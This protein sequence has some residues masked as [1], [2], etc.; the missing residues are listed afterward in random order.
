[1]SSPINYIINQY[2]AK[3]GWFLKAYEP[4]TTTEKLISFDPQDLITLDKVEVASDGF[5]KHPVTGKNTILYNS[6][7]F[8]LYLIPT[9]SE[10]DS[11]D[12]TNAIKLADNVTADKDIVS[13]N[14]PNA[15]EEVYGLVRFATEAESQ[16]TTP[17]DENLGM[18]PKNLDIIATDNLSNLKASPSEIT[19]QSDGKWITAEDYDTIKQQYIPATPVH[20][21]EI[22][23]TF[24]KHVSQVDNKW[25]LQDGSPFSQSSHPTL[26]SLPDYVNYATDLTSITQGTNN[27]KI[28]SADDVDGAINFIKI[29][30]TKYFGI[31]RFKNELYFAISENLLTWSTYM[32]PLSDSG[33]DEI[34]PFKYLLAYNP[35]SDSIGA[36]RVSIGN[37]PE[38]RYYEIY[39]N[40]NNNNI[41]YL[42]EKEIIKDYNNLSTIDEFHY[43]EQINKYVIFSQHFNDRFPVFLYDQLIDIQETIIISNGDITYN[44][45]T[46]SLFFSLGIKN[47][48]N[49]NFLGGLKYYNGFYYLAAKFYVNDIYY[50][51]LLLKI[52]ENDFSYSIIDEKFISLPID[53][54]RD[55]AIN[56]NG[57]LACVISYDQTDGRVE[58]LKS[59]D[60]TTFSTVIMDTAFT[61]LNA[62]CYITPIKNYWLI[63]SNNDINTA[64]TKDLS[65]IDLETT[66]S[67]TGS[68]DYSVA[69]YNPATNEIYEFVSGQEPA[70]IY[71]IKNQAVSEVTYKTIKMV[72]TAEGSSQIV[73]FSNPTK[74]NFINTGVSS[75]S[76]KYIK[77][78]DNLY[79]GYIYEDL[80]DTEQYN[81]I[82][83]TDGENWT[84]L[85]ISQTGRSFAPHL[86]V[87]LTWDGGDYILI[88]VDAQQNISLFQISTETFST[89]NYN[90]FNSGSPSISGGNCLSHYNQNLGKFI[91]FNNRDD[92]NTLYVT[93]FENTPATRTVTTI[94]ATGMN[95]DYRFGMVQ[96]NQNYMYYKNGKYYIYDITNFKLYSLEEGVWDLTLV[97][98]F[99]PTLTPISGVDISPVFF[100][101][102][103]IMTFPISY[104][105]TTKE[106]EVAYSED[107]I[108]FE[109]RVITLPVGS[110]SISKPIVFPFG[111]VWVV[112][113]IDG[114][115]INITKD[116]S[117][118]LY[119]KNDWSNEGSG[120][121]MFFHYDEINQKAIQY[122][123]GSATDSP[124]NPIYTQTLDV[125][126]EV[127][128]SDPTFKS[129][130]YGD[131]KPYV[132]AG[133]PQV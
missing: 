10:A 48:K 5:F 125:A 128:A 96:S 9:E 80:I 22:G 92:L 26:A 11:D 77:I 93:E 23:D 28:L 105:D 54:L 34:D 82:K 103:G 116:F 87:K 130:E 64:Y 83:S 75:G 74:E 100:N 126:V 30:D 131:V 56:E 132:F 37:N 90:M 133:T 115:D 36:I 16:A 53:S 104:N 55:L 67:V 98:T 95:F 97:N 41:T 35:N 86:N 19:A 21:Y 73:G 112:K 31:I 78:S 27:T 6:G 68:P 42:F 49:N 108:V 66:F 111:D 91:M 24:F 59:D 40:N 62:F 70:G 129:R 43:N 18:S 94:T 89:L 88:T 122:T 102:D 50:S 8:D 81:M 58:I 12:L 99:T 120:N 113:N 39:F 107:M 44:G 57:Q 60:L 32:P 25:L 20:E 45:N 15:E 106:I 29:N 119:N 101:K 7:Y 46:G 47:K 63:K 76:I 72:G 114:F 71:I 38:I 52:D 33:S 123:S 127:Q 110:D 84:I 124:N 79:Y 69:A 121:Y 3:V 61:D 13:L 51:L 109:Q 118:L 117:T 2:N 14:I 17:V 1:M 4:N 65:T 85:P